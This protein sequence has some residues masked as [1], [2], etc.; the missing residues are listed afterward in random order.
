MWIRTVSG[1][2]FFKVEY[3]KQGIPYPTKEVKG[4]TNFN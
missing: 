3:T 1:W 2:K 4:K